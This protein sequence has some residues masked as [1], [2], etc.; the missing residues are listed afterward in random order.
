VRGI[1]GAGAHTGAAWGSADV[2]ILFGV[3]L[4]LTL[5]QVFDDVHLTLTSVLFSWL[6]VG[7]S[8]TNTSCR[9]ALVLVQ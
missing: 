8:S 7:V 2:L 5:V 6:L 3:L 4:A 1:V 9:L